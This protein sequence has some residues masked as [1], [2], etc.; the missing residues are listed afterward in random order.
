MTITTKQMNGKI[1]ERFTA[2]IF[3]RVCISI[4]LACNGGSTEPPRIAIIKPAAPNLASSP[5]PVKAI[6]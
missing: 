3:Q 6:P 5:K 1:N 4:M 2:G